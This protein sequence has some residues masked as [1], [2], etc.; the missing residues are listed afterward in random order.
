VRRDSTGVLLSRDTIKEGKMTLRTTLYP[1]GEPEAMTPYVGDVVEGTKKTFLV[2]GQP[3]TIEQWTNGAQNGLT[4]LFMN[5][6]KSAEIPYVNGKKEG[7]AR[8][9]RDGTILAE[10]IHW[11]N[12]KKQGPHYIYVDNQRK[13]EWFHKDKRVSR[14]TYE[15]LNRSYWTQDSP[16]EEG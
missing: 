15:R 9:F 12:D 11:E 14:L 5:G 2:G 16:E 3:N 8:Y 6:L 7:L 1:S 4:V 13:T 10:E